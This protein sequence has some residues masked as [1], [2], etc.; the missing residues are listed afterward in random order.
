MLK[1]VGGDGGSQHCAREYEATSASVQT[2]SHAKESCTTVPTNVVIAAS[3]P[4]C[5]SH[6]ALQQPSLKVLERVFRAASETQRNAPA[7]VPVERK[8]KGL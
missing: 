3:I 1:G 5:V 2:V 8:L 4:T 7:F 6:A